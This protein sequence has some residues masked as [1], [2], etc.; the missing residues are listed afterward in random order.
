MAERGRNARE[1]DSRGAAEVARQA[2]D[3]FDERPGDDRPD[4]QRYYDDL[5]RAAVADDRVL[6]FL[7][8]TDLGNAERFV[9]RNGAMAK[10]VPEDGWRTWDGKRWTREGADAAVQLAA[11]DTVRAIQDEAKAIE[12]TNDD[13]VV[14]VKNDEEIRLSD[15]L[16]AW[17]A[18]RSQ[19]RGWR[20]Y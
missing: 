15:K 17:G 16:A 5:Q 11:N 9:R 3:R 13:V 8:Q 7:P 2:L 14:A 6:A 19:Q 12:G 4:D 20:R 10:W 1:V 18:H